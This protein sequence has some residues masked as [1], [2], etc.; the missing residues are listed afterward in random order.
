[1]CGGFPHF[2]LFVC[3]FALF[4]FGLH[5]EPMFVLSLS[6]ELKKEEAKMALSMSV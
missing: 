6:Y 2:G 4:C 5:E 3:L 1:M